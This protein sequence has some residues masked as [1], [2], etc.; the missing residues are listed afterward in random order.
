[1]NY[2]PSTPVASC[3]AN[4]G[5]YT[6]S[7]ACEY[8][9]DVTGGGVILSMQKAWCSSYNGRWVAY[10]NACQFDS[11][12]AGTPVPTVPIV[13]TTPFV[14]VPTSYEKSKVSPLVWVAIGVA[15]IGGGFL[16]LR[17]K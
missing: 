11:V 5:V 13:D 9:S 12:P 2:C 17:K 16:L 8:P 1:M 15:V 4:G 6:P 3:E 14:P 10:N 7:C